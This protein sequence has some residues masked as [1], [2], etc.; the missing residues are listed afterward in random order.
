[1]LSIFSRVYW[2]SVWLLWRNVYLGLLSFFDWVIFLLLSCMSCLYILE[3]KPLL[4]A[5][6]ADIFSQS[7]GCLFVLFMIS[8]AVQKLISLIRS[9]HLF[10]YAFIS[11]A[12]GDWPKK[13]LVRFM[14]EKVLPMFSSRSFT[15][16]C[17][18]FKSLSHFEFIFVYGVRV[19]SNIIDLYAAVQLSLH[20]LLKRL[21]FLHESS[22]LFVSIS[23]SISAF[24]SLFQSFPLSL[25][26][27]QL[28]KVL[29]PFYSHLSQ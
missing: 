20:H 11:I 26:L 15:V 22:L 28:S 19:C 5:S 6:F 8:F 16:T 13:T 18:I 29:S 25:F 12:L 9:H 23:V 14:S 1:M 3:I 24:Q 21:C 7:V 2:P 27:S 4:V 17:L 10:I